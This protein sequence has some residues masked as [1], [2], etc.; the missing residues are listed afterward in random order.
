MSE[1]FYKVL[2]DLTSFL[3]L[4]FEGNVRVLLLVIIPYGV[5]S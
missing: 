4:E 1:A 3:H 5:V 2:A